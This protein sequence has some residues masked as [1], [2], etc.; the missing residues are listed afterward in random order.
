MPTRVTDISSSLL[1]L[2]LT[3]TPNV[4]TESLLLPLISTSDHKL[5]L[6]YMESTCHK[7]LICDF[8]QCDFAALNS[9]LSHAPIDWGYTLLNEIDDVIQYWFDLYKTTLFK[10]IP[11]RTISTKSNDKPWV[12]G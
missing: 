8:K 1:D 12:T 3:D 2:I 11:H 9:C 7:R 10:V 6:P 5:A 4:V